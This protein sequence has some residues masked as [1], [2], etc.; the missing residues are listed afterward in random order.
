MDEH[1]A[2]CG[3]WKLIQCGDNLDDNL[4]DDYICEQVVKRVF[5]YLPVAS[6]QR[7]MVRAESIKWIQWKLNCGSDDAIGDWEVDEIDNSPL[8]DHVECVERKLI[9]VSHDE[10]VEWKLIPLAQ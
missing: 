10:F 5:L 1:Q 6:C 9:E 3:E 4:V 8:V 7:W 2:Q